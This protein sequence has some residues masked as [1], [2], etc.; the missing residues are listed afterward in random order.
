MTLKMP[1]PP[2]MGRDNQKLNRWL[3]EIQSILNTAGL[4]DPGNIVGLPATYTQTGN[5]TVDIA[6]LTGVVNALGAVVA[7][8][9][10]NIAANAA[11][12]AT[13][14]TNIVALQ[15]R[16]QVR[17]GGIAPAAGLGSIG[18]WYADTTGL[19]IYVKTGVATWTLVI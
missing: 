19:H 6:A 1:P 18:D 12:I 13:N 2:D 9:T 3:L 14:T 7:E 5:N 15:A 11:N 10:V 16:S 8:N 17:N 4:I